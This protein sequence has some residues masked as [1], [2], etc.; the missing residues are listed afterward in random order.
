MEEE[1]D[2]WGKR[3]SDPISSR[4]AGS[5]G[6]ILDRLISVD[7]ITEVA[8]R[9]IL[10]RGVYDGSASQSAGGLNMSDCIIQQ[11]GEISPTDQRV[12]SFPRLSLVRQR[13]WKSRRVSIG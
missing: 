10:R 8:Y 5:S 4:D 13:E 1:K 11:L 3:C 6:C 7:F 9:T 12:C 2:E